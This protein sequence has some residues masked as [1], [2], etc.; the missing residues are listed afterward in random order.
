M[1]CLLSEYLLAKALAQ[2]WRSDKIIVDS[3]FIGN[4]TTF[5]ALR[6]HSDDPR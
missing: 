1:D 2:T 4:M 6:V 3:A 5:V